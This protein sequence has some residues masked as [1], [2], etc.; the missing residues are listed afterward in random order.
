MED[1]LELHE[2]E[3]TP[4]PK[5]APP[6]KLTAQEAT[7]K[8]GF[9]SAILLGLLGWFVRDGWFN[10]DPKMLEH[11]GFNRIG[12]VVIGLILIYS[13]IM[14]ASAAR[15]LAREKDQPPPPSAP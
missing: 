10:Q 8:Y 6:P 5:P 12:S 13:V 14:F 1:K 9:Q 4:P 7:K 15:T 2:P 11:V 3:S